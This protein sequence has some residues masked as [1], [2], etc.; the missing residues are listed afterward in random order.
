MATVNIFRGGSPIVNYMWCGCGEGHNEFRPPFQPRNFDDTPP[1]NGKVAAEYAIGYF[2]NGFALTPVDSEVLRNKLECADL[3]VGD[4]IR[5][6]ILP[7]SSFATF[8]DWRMTGEDA[9]MAGASFSLVMEEVT[10]DPDTRTATYTEMPIL[11]TALSDQG[12][13]NS[14]PADAESG[15]F[16]SLVGPRN[17]S[18]FVLPEYA[19][20]DSGG[21]AFGLKVESLPTNTD[22][23]IADMATRFWLC[24]KMQGI[25]TPAQLF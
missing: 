5:L 4:I 21:I 15:E 11:D 19:A 17:G 8:V 2:T 7:P 18:T 25:E 1:H 23:S 20:P 9:N 22:F 24:V 13:T 12:I 10:W 16:F 3:A 6:I 14:I